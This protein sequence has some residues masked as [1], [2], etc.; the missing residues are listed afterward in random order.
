MEE[1][2]YLA[3]CAIIRDEREDY[4]HEWVDYHLK[5]G[6]DFICIYDNGSYKPINKT[7]QDVDNVTIVDWP[8]DFKMFQAYQNFINRFRGLVKWTAFIDSDEFLIPRNP[9]IR[10]DTILNKYENFGGLAANWLLFGSNNKTCNKEPQLTAFT[11]RASDN[12]EL[13]SGQVINSHVKSIVQL[14]YVISPRGAHNFE[15]KKGSFCVNEKGAKVSNAFS[16]LTYGLIN[17]NHYFLR[18]YED[19]A[20]K[21]K[22]IGPEVGYYRKIEEFQIIDKLCSVEDLTAVDIRDKTK[23]R[24]INSYYNDSFYLITNKDVEE[25]IR[26]NKISCGLE[27]WL[28]YGRYEKRKA[29]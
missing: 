10:V 27:H 13:D 1:V 20:E 25:A 26:T 6:V 3:I 15:Y 4:L 8:G 9:E 24:K 19:F 23:N 5:V 14:K 21:V 2:V 7:L 12:A 16:N 18:S 28:R 17:I 22:K 11:K 29:I